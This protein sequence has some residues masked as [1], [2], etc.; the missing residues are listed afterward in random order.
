MAT[1]ASSSTNRTRGLSVRLRSTTAPLPPFV[2]SDGLKTRDFVS[3]VR[4]IANR[5]RKPAGFQSNAALPPSCCSM[6]AAIT[7]RPKLRDDGSATDG[8]PFSTQCMVSASA[9]NSH[10]RLTLPLGDDNA[11]CLAAL[12][13]RERESLRSGGLQR[14]V[15]PA[16]LDLVTGPIWRQLLAH[17]S[18]EIGAA[19]ARVGKKRVCTR[20]RF[21]A[22]FD[23]LYIFINA[24]CACQPDDGLN[25]GKRVARTVIDLPRQKH[26]PLIGFLTIR[27]IDGDAVDAHDIFGIIDACCRRSDARAHLAIR[28]HHTEF[29][30]LRARAARHATPNFDQRDPVVGMDQRADV[31]HRDLEI[32]RVNAKYTVLAFVPTPL[33]AHQVPIPGTHLTGGKREAATLL[34]LL[35]LHIRSFKLRSAFGHV[36]FQPQVHLLELAGFS[37]QFGKYAH[38]GA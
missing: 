15:G 30:L 20:Q 31:L 24:F 29:G 23:C 38:F 8:P 37:E 10:S 12:V 17:K 5:Q 6:L 16:A 11:P 27:N 19:P 18:T 35:E 13:E 7:F 36:P 33:L 26:L 2:I 1:S 34:G 21:D 32:S 14:N 4:G 3:S 22:A 9:P 28:P 25:D